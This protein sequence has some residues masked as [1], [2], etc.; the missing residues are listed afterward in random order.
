M[1]EPDTP[2]T[3]THPTN[4]PDVL[5]AQPLEDRSLT[6]LL[7]AHGRGEAGAFE[8]LL[9][10]VY[11]DLRRLAH[12]KL[13]DRPNHNLDSRALVHETYLKIARRPPARWRDRAHFRAAFAQAM[14]HI[15]VDAARQRLCEKRGGGRLDETLTDALV[16]ERRH[17]EKI[18]ALEQ[19]LD[20]LRN[21][22]PR[23]LR[24]V[25][26]RFF[27]G[28]SETETADCLGVSVRTVHRDWQRARAWLHHRLSTDAS[29]LGAAP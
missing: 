19:V 20:R 6:E 5:T 7:E 17:A 13:R 27:V 8:H 22:D 12:L 29:Q 28:L 18:L 2:E 26:C 23:L 9:Q 24:V 21:F 11:Q 25:E 1:V 14:R 16:A 4:P 15:L 10:L 3:S